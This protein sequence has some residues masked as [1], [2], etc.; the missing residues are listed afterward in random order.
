MCI[1]CVQLQQ[2]KLTAKEA[3]HNFYEMIGEIDQHHHVEVA[4]KIDK[5]WEEEERKRFNYEPHCED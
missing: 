2:D 4:K 1:I 5:K 3:R